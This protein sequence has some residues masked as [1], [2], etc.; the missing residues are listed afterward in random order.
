[1][2]NKDCFF[3]KNNLFANSCVVNTDTETSWTQTQTNRLIPILHIRAFTSLGKP[4]NSVV[5]SILYLRLHDNDGT[6]LMLKFFILSTIKKSVIKFV[7]CRHWTLNFFKK[8]N[9]K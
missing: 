8:L 7:V 4:W 3:K 9:D 1:M 6:N 5:C 2:I